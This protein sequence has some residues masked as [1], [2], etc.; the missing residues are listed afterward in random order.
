ETARDDAVERVADEAQRDEHA[1]K[2]EAVVAQAWEEARA[3]PGE[4]RLLVQFDDLRDDRDGE[5]PG[6]AV[7]QR[8]EVG[9]RYDAADP[10]EA[11]DASA[12]RVA[13][14]RRARVH[15]HAQRREAR[16]VQLGAAK[17]PQ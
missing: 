1:R 14:A 8:E 2:Q 15:A 17:L 4:E 5:E 13:K 9:R 10:L 6:E 16:Q 3:K 11:R 7:R 12:D